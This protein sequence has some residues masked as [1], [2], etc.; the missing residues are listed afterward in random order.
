MA[1]SEVFGSGI[2]SFISGL[3][4]YKNGNFIVF[5]GETGTFFI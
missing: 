4:G 5:G 3:W 2:I 1:F